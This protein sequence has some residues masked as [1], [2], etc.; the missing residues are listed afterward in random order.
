MPKPCRI[1]S[2]AMVAVH[3]RGRVVEEYGYD[4]TTG[5]RIWSKDPNGYTTRNEYDRLGRLIRQTYPDGFAKSWSYDDLAN[6]VTATDEN[7]N[8]KLYRYDGIGRL[9]SVA[10]LTG[11]TQLVAH[12]YDPAGSRVKSTD[13]NGNVTKLVRDG[14][15]RLVRREERDPANQLLAATDVNYDEAAAASDGLTYLRIGVNRRGDQ[16]SP[17]Q[18][19]SYYFNPPGQ[20]ARESRAHGGS[21]Y[22]KLYTYNYAGNLTSET[23]YQGKVTGYEVDYLGRT[24]SVNYPDGA[25]TRFDYDLTG[26]VD[27]TDANGNTTFYIRDSLGRVVRTIAPFEAG[28]YAQTRFHYDPAGNLTRRVDPEGNAV[29]YRYD[30]RHRLIRVQA[31]PDAESRSIALYDYDGAGNLIRSRTGLASDDD[32]SRGATTYAYDSRNRVTI[33]TDP[34]GAITRFEYDPNGNL[35]R[36]IDRR[37]IAT[38]MTYDGLD[39]LILRR[40]GS[41]DTLDATWFKYDSLGQRLEMSDSHGSGTSRYRYDDLGRL[42]REETSGGIERRYDYD[43]DGRRI[44]FELSEHGTRRQEVTYAYDSRGRLT[45]VTSAGETVRYGYDLQGNRTRMANE[46]IGIQETYHYNRANFLTGMVRRFGPEIRDIYEYQYDLAGRQIEKRE[47]NGP[48]KYG[49]D[50]MG[51]LTRI[52]EPYGE[53]TE[54]R[55]DAAGNRTRQVVI[56]GGR[57]TMTRYSYDQADRLLHEIETFGGTSTERTYRYDSEGNQTE[58]IEK[59]RA[60]SPGVYSATTS[61]AYDPLGRLSEV[62]RPDGVTARY[63]YNGDGLRV[64]KTVSRNNVTL[65]GGAHQALGPAFSEATDFHWDGQEVVL[66]TDGDGFVTGLNLYGPGIISRTAGKEKYYYLKNPHGDVEALV[67]SG[68]RVVATYGYQAF[69]TAKGD[70]A[71]DHGERM[72]IGQTN[73]RNPFRYTGQYFDEETGLYYLRARYYNSAAG[74]FISEDTYRG[75][76][77]D[78]LTLNLYIYAGNSPLMYSDPSGHFFNLATAAIGAGIG[79]GVNVIFTAIADY[80]DDREFS[81]EWTEYAGAFAEGAIGGAAA[82]ITLGGSLAASLA[83]DVGVGA[84]FS[85]AGNATEQL[86]TQDEVDFAEVGFSALGGGIGAGVGRALAGLGEDIVKGAGKVQAP[87]KVIGHYPE[88][89]EMSGK[90]GTKP[91]SIPDNIWSKMTPSEQWAANQ[92]FLDRTI[93]KGSEFNLATPIDKVRPGSFLQKEIEYL[94]SQGYKLSSDGTKLVK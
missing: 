42:I 22:W 60:G 44:S 77:T 46:A 24:K 13:A 12:E 40:A 64:K 57:P 38:T 87:Q 45:A 89:V 52:E 21:E 23:D 86:I 49:Y 85:A 54:Y 27:E 14:L 20:L 70:A 88:Y 7:S 68:R 82:G 92:K 73:L 62:R 94:T 67:D 93:A 48:I 28:R 17:D 53:R 36:K 72:P 16:Y 47:S 41:G 79:G 66:E 9:S 56:S 91:F 58:L 15:G 65:V 6:T 81:R 31:R 4:Y 71:Y 55:Y 84:A 3:L 75:N 33:I 74:R 2:M 10:D 69:G 32:P 25:R 30:S 39:R 19:Q 83:L 5:W 61:Y 78:L 35:V 29:D 1:T 90:L 37:G 63:H 34:L 80:L 51:R 50:G 43:A 11:K 76:V 26:L 59:S 8:Q 18:L